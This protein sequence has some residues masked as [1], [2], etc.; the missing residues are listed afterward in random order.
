MGLKKDG[1]VEKIYFSAFK[2]NEINGLNI[3]IQSVYVEHF[4]RLLRKSGNH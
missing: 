2:L 3:F 1:F 4:T